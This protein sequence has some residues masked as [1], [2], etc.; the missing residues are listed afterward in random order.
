M[1]GVIQEIEDGKVYVRTE[2]GQIFIIPIDDID[3]FS[4]QKGDYLLLAWEKD[5]WQASKISGYK[6]S[7]KRFKRPLVIGTAALIVAAVLITIFM[8]IRIPHE[9]SQVHS[10][11]EVSSGKIQKGKSEPLTVVND[12]TS[13][14]VTT[15]LRNSEPE[16]T[17]DWTHGTITVTASTKQPVEVEHEDIKIES[18]GYNSHIPQGSKECYLYSAAIIKNPNKEMA[19]VSPRLKITAKDVSGLV[20]GTQT[21]GAGY[22]MPN[23]T[24]A[25]GN[26]MDIGTTAPR[27]VEFSVTASN[28]VSASDLDIPDSS[29]FSVKN[30]AEIKTRGREK[31]TGNIVYNGQRECHYIELTALFMRDG[32]IVFP[33]FGHIS[34]PEKGKESAFEINPLIPQLPKHDSVEVFARYVS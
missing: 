3:Y 13:A 24:I 15:L 26:L 23:D 12:A 11:S 7:N 6:G 10:Q 17:P 2:S 34:D 9:N 22:I 18:T 27:T 5:H 1:K 20:L 19:A 32:K 14:N 4:P 28:Y 16:S 8:M 31:V 30:T 21:I 33:A 29:D 25:L